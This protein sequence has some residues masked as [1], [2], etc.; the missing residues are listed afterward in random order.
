MSATAWKPVH[1]RVLWAMWDLGL[2][3][4][5][6]FKKSA[7]VVGETMAKYHP[8]GDASIY[9]T[10]VRMAQDFSLRYPLVRGQGNFG[11]VDGDSPA[12]IMRYTESQ[13]SPRIANEMLAGYRKRK[14]LIGSRTTTARAT[15]RPCFPQSCRTCF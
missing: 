8:H 1:R 11:S 5:A 12:A 10:L 7:F 15:S 2:T 13:S 3:R 14:L 9:D 6:K 4:T